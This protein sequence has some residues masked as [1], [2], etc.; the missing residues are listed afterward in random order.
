VQRLIKKETNLSIYLSI[1]HLYQLS[2]LSLSLS[3]SH[4]WS[5]CLPTYLPTYRD[6]VV[7]AHN[8]VIDSQSNYSRLIIPRRWYRV[9]ISFLSFEFNSNDFLIESPLLLC[10]TI[11]TFSVVLPV[12]DLQWTLTLKCCVNSSFSFPPSFYHLV[13]WSW[14]LWNLFSCTFPIWVSLGCP[15]FAFRGFLGPVPTQHAT[16]SAGVLDW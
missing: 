14:D 10:H 3:L 6:L 5:I 2:I 8:V 9:G 16:L 1:R 7:F 11:V 13:D 15:L 12:N 4:L